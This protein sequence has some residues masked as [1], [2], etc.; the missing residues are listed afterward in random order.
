MGPRGQL[1]IEPIDEQGNLRVSVTF[2]GLD[3]VDAWTGVWDD[4][5]KRIT[6]R[7]LLPNN[8]TQDHEGFL[9]DNDP[10]NLIFGGSFTES[11]IPNNAPRTHFGWF[12]FLPT[13]P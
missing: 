3:R 6:L 7:R 1:S 12:A 9:G 10:N 2:E 5:A 8:I 11:D 4:R 13:I